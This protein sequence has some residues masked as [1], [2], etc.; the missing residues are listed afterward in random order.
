MKLHTFHL[1]YG[2]RTLS[3]QI[4]ARHLMDQILPEVPVV[5]SDEL[6]PVKKAMDQPVQS[7]VLEELVRPN[8]RVLILI[9]DKTRKCQVQL[10]L[11]VLI[12]RLHKLG[13]DRKQIKILMAM[14]S[15]LPQK[16]EEIKSLVGERLYTQFSIVEH[17]CHKAETLKY[18]GTT[19]RGTP[20]YLNKELFENDRIFVV[21]TAVH[22]YFAGYGGG[23]KMINPGCAGYETIRK[24]HALTIDLESGGIHPRC[25]S[26]VIQ[27]NPVMEDILESMQWVRVDFLIETVLDAQGKIIAAIA[28]DLLA[29]HRQACALVDDFYKIPIP[30]KADL[31]VASCGGYPKD[32]N[33]IQAHKSLHNAFQA[34]KAGGVIL[35]LAECRDG[36]GSR[37]FLPWF[38]Y[39]DVPQMLKALKENYTLNGTTALSVKL[40]SQ[41]VHIILV[42]SLEDS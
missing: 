28:G 38:D 37:T 40:K 42:S 36:I 8:D 35:L 5:E 41:Q 22:H 20:V 25:Q 14:G 26:G 19:T 32:I 9:P 29:A 15:H 33:F 7:P 21:G 39:P 17:D 12:Q 6:T 2:N 10:I 34:V 27:G 18:M 23:P 31:V 30:E 24:N 4:E 11:P 16:P 13:V 1:A 3:F